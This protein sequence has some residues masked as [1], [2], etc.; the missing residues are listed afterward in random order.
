M[1]GVRDFRMELHRHQRTRA[2]RHGGHGAS[3]SA[4]KNVEAFG[5]RLHLIAMIHPNL[6]LAVQIGQELVRMSGV[7]SR[8]AVLAFFALADPA[9]Q[10]I[11]H[12]LLAVADAEHG[13]ISARICGSICGLPAS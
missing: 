7:E 8:E 9:A 11:G 5:N 13:A 10:H 3:G 4:A 2:M 12:E 1:F 6:Q